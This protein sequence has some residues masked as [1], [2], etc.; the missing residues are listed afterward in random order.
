MKKIFKGLM[1]LAFIFTLSTCGTKSNGAE[2]ALKGYLVKIQKAEHIDKND[3]QA[4]MFKGIFQNA[5]YKINKVTEKGE[6]GAII[7]M[8]IKT[9]NFPAYMGEFMEK[10]MPLAFSG[11]SEEVIAESGTKYFNDLLK[12]NDLD[13]KETT[14][15]VIMKKKENEWGIEN[16]DEMMSA[17]IAGIDKMM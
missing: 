6:N 11:A 13:Y 12:R 14:I 7:N 15:D 3:P 10:M 5:T 8:T 1:L 9:I 16:S 17:F 2:K 4:A